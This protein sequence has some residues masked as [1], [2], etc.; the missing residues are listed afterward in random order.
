MTLFPVMLHYVAQFVTC[1]M[2]RAWTIDSNTIGFCC[3]LYGVN[4]LLELKSIVP[5][6]SRRSAL[7]GSLTD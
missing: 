4:D 7:Q 1:Y 3:E 6:P 5:R 2:S